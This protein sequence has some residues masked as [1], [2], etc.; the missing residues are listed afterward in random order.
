MITKEE[1]NKY[2]IAYSQGNPLI[3][4]EEYDEL[5]EE[6]LRAHGEDK[7]PFTRQKQS[8][9]VNDIVGTLPKVYGVKKPMRPD[10]KVYAGWVKSKGVTHDMQICLQPKFDGCSVALDLT[11]E[12]FFTRGDYDDG[13]S[14]DVT[15]LFRHHLTR[16]KSYVEPGTLAMKFE[17]IVSHEA[18]REHQLNLKYKRPRDFVSATIT[19]RNE[20]YAS[21]ITLVPLRGYLGHRQYIPKVLTNLPSIY[22]DADHYEA[23]ENFIKWKL[24][25]GASV[26][27]FDKTYSIDGVVA[28]VVEINEI[29]GLT[30][31]V[32][33]DL[34]VAIKILNNVQK[35]K[36][37]TVDYQ[38]GKQGRIT[39]VAILEP[40][41]FDNVVVD[42]V[43]LSTLERVTELGL[44]HN[45]TV[46][47]MYNI[48][49]YLIDSEH[50]G[51]YPVPVPTTC[52]ICGAKLDYQTLK[53]VRCSN[54][55]CKGL[56]L[57]AI[58]RYAEKM[59]MFGVSKGIL[60][61]LYDAG[62]VKSIIDLYR[63]N[64]D[65][66]KTMSGFGEVSANNIC[67]SIE[68]A[69]IGCPP[70]RF[71]GA[72]PIN[73]TSEETWKQVINAMGV[74]QVIDSLRSKSF[75]DNIMTV[76]YIPGVGEIK[77]RKLIDGV[78]RNQ[79]EISELMDI[80]RF[81]IGGPDR[82]RGKL[83]MT[84]TRDKEAIAKL[85]SWGWEVGSFTNDCKGLI[86]PSY[87]FKSAKTEK[88]KKLGIDIVALPDIDRFFEE[89]F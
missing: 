32:N 34:E 52:P 14:V 44:R 30:F 19:S 63:L 81:R 9:A 51:D 72:L 25:E 87:D 29:E 67:K 66:F 76:G 60:T 28:S 80:I 40:V 79:D 7:R 84:G 58:V 43:T 73:D 75:V 35:T 17:A 69:S 20:Q 21:L 37:V 33:P 61:K 12:R 49:P 85:E 42:H 71:L 55:D 13:E 70:S 89:P 18:Y 6:Y 78:I 64:P 50:D 22:C 26:E 77:L 38:F 82:F 41:K 5:L 4:N 8:D 57:G 24:E 46:R 1:L 16:I 45:D 36:L 86:V 54:P 48:V 62:L 23:I 15:D 3:S 74:I 10:Q 59:K 27:L 2:V 65:M 68:S 83:C 31:C 56:K 11:T 88:A 53:Q 39:P 47:V